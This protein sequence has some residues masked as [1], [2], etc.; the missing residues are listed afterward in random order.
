MK[1]RQQTRVTAGSVLLLVFSLSCMTTGRASA[2]VIYES[3]TG[4]L[5]QSLGSAVSTTQYLGSRFTLIQTAK[6]TSIGGAFGTPGAEI[7]GAILEMSGLLPQGTPFNGTEVL[8]TTLFTT[9]NVGDTI[10]PL[11][12]Y[13]PAGDYAV[14]FGTDLFGATGAATMD[15]NGTNT[16][17]G[18]GS[19]FY[20]NNGSAWVNGSINN[21]RFIVNGV[22][23][24]ADLDGDGDVDAIDITNFFTYFTGPGGGPP[25]DPDADLDGDGDVDGVDLSLAFAAFTG[26]LAPAGSVPEPSSLALLGLG[27][28]LATRR[29]PS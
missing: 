10:A 3:S 20:W 29:R 21:T 27:G 22:L 7:F 1:T 23:V 19:Y 16:P 4:N 28:V 11:S 17:E 14:V 24:P 5:N 15:Y 18:A 2:V 12:I 26:P 8:T 25:D 13:L 9:T 6:V